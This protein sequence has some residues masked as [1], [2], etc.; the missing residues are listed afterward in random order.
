[1]RVKRCRESYSFKEHKFR[2]RRG[3]HHHCK[4]EKEKAGEE[5]T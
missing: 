3:H 5:N 1:M 4:Q 2:D